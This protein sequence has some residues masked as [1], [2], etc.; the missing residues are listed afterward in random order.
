T[1]LCSATRLLAGGPGSG[2]AGSVLYSL[3]SCKSFFA[4]LTWLRRSGGSLRLG[5]ARGC[6]S[7]R[8]RDLRRHRLGL[9]DR[10]PQRTVRAQP[11]ERADARAHVA[12]V[13]VVLR[14]RR[15]GVCARVRRARRLACFDRR[16]RFLERDHGLRHVA[17]RSVSRLRVEQRRE[18]LCRGAQALRDRFA[19]ELAAQPGERVIERLVVRR[20]SA[21]TTYTSES[22]IEDAH[23][24]PLLPQ[25]TW[26]S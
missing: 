9:R 4:F 3:H 19:P 5:L 7:D 12:S 11:R 17:V 15:H 21:L 6:C 10:R 1:G 22:S 2:A 23:C 26:R 18:A 13:C 20:A 8:R 14:Q 24:P 16:E 25:E